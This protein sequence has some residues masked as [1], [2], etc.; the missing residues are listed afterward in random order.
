MSKTFKYI[1]THCNIVTVLEKFGLTD[2]QSLLDQYILPTVKEYNVKKNVKIEFD[3]CISVCCEANKIDKQMDL[4]NEAEKF[5]HRL[6][7]GFGIHP[8]DAKKYE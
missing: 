6:F 8:C 3:G 4:L 1:D 2:Y 5:N 7:G